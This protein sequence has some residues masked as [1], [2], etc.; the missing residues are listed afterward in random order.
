MQ[1]YIPHS[2]KPLGLSNCPLPFNMPSHFYI[3]SLMHHSPQCSEAGTIHTTFTDK[4]EAQR[5]SVTCQMPRGL[6]VVESGSEPVFLISSQC[7][8]QRTTGHSHHAACLAV[9]ATTAL[10]PFLFR[11]ILPH[12]KMYTNAGDER[13]WGIWQIHKRLRKI[14]SLLP[15]A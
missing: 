8:C 13:S 7:F 12:F 1:K 14:R 15:T 2:E 10:L 4:G 6:S 5:G 3:Y 11:M 9:A